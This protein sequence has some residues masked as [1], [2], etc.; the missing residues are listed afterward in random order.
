MVKMTLFQIKSNL[1]DLERE[2]DES[3]YPRDFMPMWQR[4]RD[5]LYLIYGDAQQE[6]GNSETEESSYFYDLRAM[7]KTVENFPERLQLIS[8]RD[9]CRELEEEYSRSLREEER[10]DDETGCN[11]SL[12]N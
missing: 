6:K 9:R 11:C 2:V 12:C 10:E 1:T 8:L 7:I 3:R 4:L 5:E